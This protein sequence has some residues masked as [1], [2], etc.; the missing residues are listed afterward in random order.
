MQDKK[1]KSPE[2]QDNANQSAA[3]NQG[4][5]NASQSAKTPE[6]DLVVGTLQET[7]EQT[8][9]LAKQV[10]SYFPH[11]IVGA[12]FSIAMFLLLGKLTDWIITGV[13]SRLV[14]KTRSSLDDKILA[15]LHRPIFLSVLL[16]GLGFVTL[17]LEQSARVTTITVQVLQTI[18]VFVWFRFA[19]Q[20]ASAVLNELEEKQETFG[21]V[22]STTKPLLINS[23]SLVMAAVGVYVIF[24]IWSINITAWIASAGI[25]GLAVSFAAKDTL[26]NVFGGIAIFA[27]KPFKVGDYVVLTDGERGMITQIGV[28]STRIL[29]RD[30]V[31]ITVP[32]GILATT[33]VTNESGG[34]HEKFRIRVKI[35][36]AYGSDLDIVED[37]LID[38]A[39]AHPDVCETPEPRVRLRGFGDWSLDHEL[40]C[41]VD[42]PVLRGRVL[43]EL[44]RGVYKAF[45]ENKIEIP[46]P[47]QEIQMSNGDAS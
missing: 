20:T 31:E 45:A 12:L 47:R 27:D 32:N 15:L 16:I 37:T 25:I 17:Q 44:N 30:D 7:K 4:N 21:F 41:W 10:N 9:S 23:I 11:P 39:E 36:V 38:I 6:T 40:L 2:Q 26:A 34:R 1:P 14:L 46:F 24:L 8:R 5:T 42:K 3:P 22:T 43:H 33:T 28:R 18:A 35:G 29:T 19:L 13:F